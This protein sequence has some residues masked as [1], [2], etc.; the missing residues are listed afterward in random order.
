MPGALAGFKVVDITQGL[1]GPYCS[2]QLGDAGA[3]I[4]KIEP[5][6]GDSSR[7]MGPPFIG[8]ESA[9]YLNLNRNKRSIVLDLSKDE[10][11]DILLRLAK[12]ADVF[13]EDL[14]PGEAE[15]LGFGYEQLKKL[16]PK[17]IY[18]NISA[19]GEKGPMAQLPGSELVVQ[20]MA[21]YTNSLGA[22]GEPPVRLGTD[23]ANTNTAVF[24][25]QAITAALIHRERTGQGQRVSTSMLGSLM[26]MR[27]M[28]WVAQSEP[29]DSW[30]GFHQDTYIKPPD[31]G[32]KT[33]DGYVFLSFG[34]RDV[35]DPNAYDKLLEALGLSEMKTK[36]PRFQAP[37]NVIGGGSRYGWEVKH[38]FEEVF[39]EM[40]SKEVIGLFNKFGGTAMPVSN[41]EMVAAD[42]QV[43]ILGMI[44]EMDHPKLG[45]IKQTG[46]PWL[47]YDS[48]ADF[49][50]PP[51]ALGEHTDEILKGLGLSAAE[52]QHLRD[53][54]VTR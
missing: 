8:D 54:K 11:R 46:I 29:V 47:L 15:K 1:C 50:S 52:I 30:W 40:T 39:Q 25:F 23:V 17:I 48:P 33:K 16:N 27:G 34:L 44:R 20:A 12:D 6:Q 5:P 35:T 42:P 49:Q 36:D 51:P 24:S 22:I 2:M 37:N 32:Y 43:K 7:T 21:D 13:L 10:G 31:H 38:I 28:I 26:H 4:I 18:C 41:Y 45:K 3:Q 14:G 53:K 9:V 19:F